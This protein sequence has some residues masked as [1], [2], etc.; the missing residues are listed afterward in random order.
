M[1]RSCV[2]AAQYTS[3]SN[4]L[5]ARAR[6]AITSS[7]R[8][9]A[10]ALFFVDPSTAGEACNGCTDTYVTLSRMQ[11]WANMAHRRRRYWLLIT[12]HHLPAGPART[13]HF[14]EGMSKP[15]DVKMRLIRSSPDQNST[16]HQARHHGL[17]RNLG[18]AEIDA[19]SRY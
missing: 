13:R 1:R 16:K 12:K 10:R 8:Y 3:E 19:Q 5:H 9:N 6:P 4:L 17:E 18:R 11:A 2:Y 7:G 15:G 14:F